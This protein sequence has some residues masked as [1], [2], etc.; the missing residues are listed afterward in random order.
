LAVGKDVI[1]ADGL[2]KAVGAIWFF[3]KTNLDLCADG[4]ESG[5]R[6]RGFQKSVS[7]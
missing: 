3:L 6:Q 4:L 7:L 1:F 2:V 5:R